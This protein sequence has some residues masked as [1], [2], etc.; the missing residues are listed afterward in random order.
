MFYQA[1]QLDLGNGPS[2]LAPL[3]QQELS[4][5]HFTLCLTLSVGQLPITNYMLIT[6]P[7][8]RLRPG[9]GPSTVTVSRASPPQCP[10]GASN[11]TGSKLTF[12]STQFLLLCFLAQ[13]MTCY[14]STKTQNKDSLLPPPSSHDCPSHSNSYHVLQTL[15]PKCH[16]NAPAVSHSQG[17]LKSTSISYLDL[18]NYFLTGLPVSGFVPL[19]STFASLWMPW[20]KWFGTQALELN[21][22]LNHSSNHLTL[23]VLLNL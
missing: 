6:Q 3:S 12:L 15:L 21:L 19:Q 5:S 9:S 23:E 11:L 13:Q 14:L 16:W 4:A 1:L 10:T 2:A 17:H 7:L 18:C 20:N 8:L 22:A